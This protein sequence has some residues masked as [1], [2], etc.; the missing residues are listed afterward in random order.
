MALLY[1]STISD[2][3]VLID[4][5][6]IK[7]FFTKIVNGYTPW[8]IFTNSPSLMFQKVLNMPLSG[9]ITATVHNAGFKPQNVQRGN[10]ILK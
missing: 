1:K 5:L 2:R 7:E 9:S 3:V 10:N 8:T 4:L 6:S